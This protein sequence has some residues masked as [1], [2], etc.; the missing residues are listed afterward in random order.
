MTQLIS[1][2][3]RSQIMHL[4]R[5]LFLQ[6]FPN[7]STVAIALP[8]IKY[9]VKFYR[10]RMLWPGLI[11]VLASGGLLSGILETLTGLIAQYG[12]PAVFAAAFLEVIFPPIPS[13]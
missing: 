6:S 5:C 2:L 10:D 11:I 13:E 12:Y 4:I 7:N 3:A 8:K 1:V 9:R